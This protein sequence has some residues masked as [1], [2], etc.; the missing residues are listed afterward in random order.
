LPHFETLLATLPDDEGG[1]RAAV[2]TP[3]GLH[4]DAVPTGLDRLG[5]PLWMR[6]QQAR[7]HDGALADE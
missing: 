4:I 7:G 3:L 2:A 5:L 1:R 6:K